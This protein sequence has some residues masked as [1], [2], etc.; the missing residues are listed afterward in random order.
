MLDT[1]ATLRASALS[2]LGEICHILKWSLRSYATD[3][4]SCVVG[5]LQF[6]KPLIAPASTSLGEKKG[7]SAY[8]GDEHTDRN[9]IVRRAAILVVLLLL[10]GMGEQIL[11][12]LPDHAGDLHQEMKIVNS[13][14]PDI[15]CRGHAREALGMLDAIIKS[16]FAIEPI[17]S[18]YQIRVGHLISEVGS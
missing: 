12:I 13:L 14:D 3:I 1:S 11:E 17:D 5:V 16:Q 6:E 10:E 2:N 7:D 15:L 4:I 8:V 9:A 18:A